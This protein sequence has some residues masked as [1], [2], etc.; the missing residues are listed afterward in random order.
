MDEASS[1]YYWHDFD[2]TDP[3]ECPCGWARRAFAD[4]EAFPGTVHRTEITAAAKPHF[5]RRL[6]ETYYILSCE[7]DAQ[8]QLGRERLPLKPGVCI[9]I[10][11]GTVHRV[12][13]TATVLIFV[14]PKFDPDDEY[15]VE[16]D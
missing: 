6:T 13:G 1:A 7:S 9:V 11:P 10:P 3:V 15:L 2:Q 8:M 16:P 12:I 14:L 4:V 5:H